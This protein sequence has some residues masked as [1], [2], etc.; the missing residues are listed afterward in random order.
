[1]KKN[2]LIIALVLGIILSFGTAGAIMWDLQKIITGGQM[3]PYGAPWFAD[4]GVMYFGT[5]KDVG[6]SY[7]ET[8]D[9]RLEITGPVN[10]ARPQILSSTEIAGATGNQTTVTASTDTSIYFVDA[11]VVNKTVTLPDAALV[12]GKLYLFK[13]IVDPG[14]YYLRINATGGDD[15]EGVNYQTSTVANSA[16]QVS[17]NGTAYFIMGSVGTWVTHA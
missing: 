1:M 9:D 16:L 4:G 7:D 6:I 3:V 15:I 17:S 10:F 11:S 8:T 2:I 5:S 12:K 13:L 14:S